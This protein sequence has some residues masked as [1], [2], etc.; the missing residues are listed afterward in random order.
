MLHLN[1]Y[2]A[3]TPQEF[4]QTTLQLCVAVNH[5][6]KQHLMDLPFYYYQ[7]WQEFKPTLAPK[8]SGF[9][10]ATRTWIW[11]AFFLLHSA[12]DQKYA[13]RQYAFFKWNWPRKYEYFL[14]MIGKL[15]LGTCHLEMQTWNRIILLA[16]FQKYAVNRFKCHI[17]YVYCFH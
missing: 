10:K 8:K 3:T 17:S 11:L 13:V 7:V 5:A 16:Q 14:K 9:P 2:H 6:S 15:L 12:T 1:C 4:H